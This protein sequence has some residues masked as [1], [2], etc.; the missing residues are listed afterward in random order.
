MKKAWTLLCFFKRGIPTRTVQQLPARPKSDPPAAHSCPCSGTRCVDW[1]CR[2]APPAADRAP[3]RAAAASAGP[4]AAVR[5]RRRDQAGTA[6]VSVRRVYAAPAGAPQVRQATGPVGAAP[7]AAASRPAAPTGVIGGGDVATGNCRFLAPLGCT[8]GA[9]IDAP[10]EDG[11][12]SVAGSR[13]AAMPASCQACRHRHRRRR[14]IRRAPAPAAAATRRRRRTARQRVSRGPRT[15]AHRGR[16][17]APSA[18]ARAAAPPP[19]RR[20]HLARRGRRRRH[21]SGGRDVQDRSPRS[22]VQLNLIF[23]VFY[24]LKHVSTSEK[25]YFMA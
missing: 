18:A 16:A 3:T 6:A 21:R 22:P 5:R 20:A 12:P 4:D 1:C 23:A 19:C 11:V 15:A 9:A 13:P 24:M 2:G 8:G 10:A 7:P 17:T 25:T 14:R